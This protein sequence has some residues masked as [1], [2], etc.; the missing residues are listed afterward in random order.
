MKFRILSACALVCALGL[1][2]AARGA[3]AQG[4]AK[5]S[6]G[7]RD[8]AQKVEKGKNLEAKLQAAAAF[9]K[10]YPQSTLRKQI[11]ESLAAQVS[12]LT[13]QQQ[14]LSFAQVYQDIFNLPEEAR[15]VNA[16]LLDAY[17]NTG[18]VQEAM[19]LGSGWLAQHPDDVQTMQNL[20]IMASAQAIKGNNAFI[21]QGRQYGAKAIELVE[22]D[23]M[24][25]GWDAARWGEFKKTS[26]ATLY[27][28][29]GILA[30]KAGEKTAS[31]GLLE[32]AAANNSTDPGVYLLLSEMH[33]DEYE[34]RAKE[35]QVTST[36]E[37]ATAMKRVEEQLDKV[38]D[39]YARAVAVTEGNAQ[40]QPVNAALKQ[41]LERY[42]KFRHKNSTDGMQQL[43]DKYKRPAQ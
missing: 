36:A 41:D 22:A 14:A 11:A 25:E 15:L 38:I 16:T 29:T 23:K 27:R 10:K 1:G 4:E 33:N 43:I 20:T 17:I 32:K 6:G 31:L 7:E 19:K 26:L 37:K 35:Y 8:A 28:E 39:S 2:A 18:Q 9:V 5:V 21:A 34:M 24:P 30:Y 3:A 12:A 40:Y 42:Y 13:D